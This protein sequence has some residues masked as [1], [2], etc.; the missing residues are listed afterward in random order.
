MENIVSAAKPYGLRAETMFSASKFGL[1]EFSNNEI[2]GGFKILGL[3]EKMKRTWKYLPKEYP[4]PK[5]SPCLN[6]YKVFIAQNYGCGSI[7]EETST[8]VLS[9]PGELCTE[10]FLEIGPFETKLEAENVIKYIKTKF[11]RILVGIQKQTQSAVKRVYKY[12][13]LLD[14]TNNSDINWKKDIK[15]INNQLF[16]KFKLNKDEIEFIEKNIREMY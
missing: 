14:F 15:D 6:K 13:P 4:I 5:I 16:K 8:P 7:G 12:V 2:K 3:N 9:T 11:F 1:P 10:T